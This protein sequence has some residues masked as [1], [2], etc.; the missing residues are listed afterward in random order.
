[1]KAPGKSPHVAVIYHQFPHYRAAIMRELVTHGVCSY[2]FWGST[3]AFNGIRAFAGDELV[4]VNPLKL[5]KL[6][7][8]VKISG[9]LEPIRRREV[10]ALIILG[11]PNYLDTWAMAA[12]GRSLGKKVLFWTHGWMRPEP[13]IKQRL[14]HL[15]FGLADHV[16]VYGERARKLGIEAGFPPERISVIYNSLDFET[17]SRIFAEIEAETRHSARERP[18]ALFAEPDR[19]LIICTARL[20]PLCRFELLFEAA[21]ELKDRGRPVNILLVGD[22]SARGMLEEQARALG[23]DVVFYGAC[24]D[25]AV[26]GRL[27]YHADVTVSP[28]KIGLTVMHSLAYGTPAITHGDLNAQMPEVEAILPGVTGELF[29]NGDATDLADVIARWLDR[30]RGDRDMIR[31]ACRQVIADKWNAAHQRICIEQ[32]VLRLMGRRT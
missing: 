12:A 11:N 2:E 18:Q 29:R 16:L 24:Y 1:M 20:I 10:D 21:A 28:G 22:G 32:A 7:G 27:I 19:P 14:R 15:Y 9:Y 25:E 3:E 26:L 8:R 17:S 6:L 31:S 13:R 30:H 5:R 23:I 4:Q